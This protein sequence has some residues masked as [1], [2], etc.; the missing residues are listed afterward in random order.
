MSK[1]LCLKYRA[2]G[3]VFTL[4]NCPFYYF[5]LRYFP[6][7][8]SVQLKTPCSFIN[9]HCP[10]KNMNDVMVVNYINENNCFQVMD[11]FMTLITNG[12]QTG[13]LDT[14]SGTQSCFQRKTR[15]MPLPETC[16]YEYC[17]QH[18]AFIY[19][20]CP[21]EERYTSRRLYYKEQDGPISLTWLPLHGEVTKINRLFPAP[22][23]NYFS[24]VLL[25]IRKLEN[26]PCIVN[27]HHT[28]DMQRKQ[29]LTL[30]LD[31]WAKN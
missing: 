21:F 4:K 20:M 23:V 15:Y 5:I 26:K 29:K 9:V 17:T 10:N 12:T 7:L 22:V 25:A 30:A 16:M 2:K 13:Y 28:I 3:H 14:I 19:Y 31:R 24:L 6:H 1:W 11:A 18:T 27:R 8:T